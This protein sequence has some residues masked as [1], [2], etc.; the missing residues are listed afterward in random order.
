MNLLVLHP[1]LVHFPIAFIW[2]ELV[3]L[4]WAVRPGCEVYERFAF[5]TFCLTL[6]LL[7]PVMAA[8]LYDAGGFEGVKGDV[9]IHAFFGL[10]VFLVYGFRAFLWRRIQTHPD[11]GR[12]FLRISAAISAALVTLAGFW[13]GRLVY[14]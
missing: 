1:S 6:S 11:A 10:G 7:L 5:V 8:G 2:L 13:G 3:L 4:I 14:T 12:A 9:R